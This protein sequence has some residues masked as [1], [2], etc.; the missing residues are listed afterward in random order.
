MKAL[1][2]ATGIGGVLNQRRASRGSFEDR[3]LDSYEDFTLY[4][5]S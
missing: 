4:R 5:T 3:Q 2:I 1:A